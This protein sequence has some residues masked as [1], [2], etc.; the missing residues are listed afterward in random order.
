MKLTEGIPD[1]N[2]PE[3]RLKSRKKLYDHKEPKPLA[4]LSYSF[5]IEK[6]GQGDVFTNNEA[7]YFLKKNSK[8]KKETPAY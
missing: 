5:R 8:K 2:I 4:I 6:W 1:H 7:I 3:S